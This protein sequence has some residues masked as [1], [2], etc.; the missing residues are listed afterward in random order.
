MHSAHLGFGPVM[1]LLKCWKHGENEKKTS[2]LLIISGAAVASRYTA[3][4]QADD[5]VKRWHRL[6]RAKLEFIVGWHLVTTASAG[7]RRTGG[8]QN[9]AC[10]R[11]P[12]TRDVGERQGRRERWYVND[13]AVIR[14]WTN[15]IFEIRTCDLWPQAASG[16]RL[17]EVKA[18]DEQSRWMFGSG[19][20]EVL[21]GV[22]VCR[23]GCIDF[24]LL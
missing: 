17:L 10:T 20:E 3:S 9:D 11:L 13:K 2:N 15:Q 14:T 1:L 23:S 7:N 8:G 18:P 5:P 21:V 4:P 16:Q 19:K 6:A 22:S 24:D 12:N